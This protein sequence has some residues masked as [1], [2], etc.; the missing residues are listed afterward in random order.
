MAALPIRHEEFTFIDF[1]SGKGKVLLL[2]SELPFKA[3]VGIEFS[4]DLYEVAQQNVAR[5][6]TLTQASS[7]IDCLLLDA[8]L[9]DIPLG[10]KVCYFFNPYHEPVMTKV[11]RRLEASLIA[12]PSP[13]FI[14]YY[15]PA[16]QHIFRDSKYFRELR[17]KQEYAIYQST[18]GAV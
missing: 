13:T 15:R 5:H 1:G 9:Y 18:L 16:L 8:T 2:A 3:I 12:S 11:V 4:K 14:L 6:K 10:P 17:V 7:P